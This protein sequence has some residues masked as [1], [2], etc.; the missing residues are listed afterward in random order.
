M[1]RLSGF[2]PGA[3]LVYTPLWMDV[4]ASIGGMSPDIYPVPGQSAGRVLE[5][6]AGVDDDAVPPYA[7]RQVRALRA[8]KGR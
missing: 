5:R 3:E 4:V 8:A 6:Y 2:E 7:Q 1:L